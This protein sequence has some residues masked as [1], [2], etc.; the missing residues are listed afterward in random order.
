MLRF[1]AT[2]KT[3][4]GF[5]MSARAIWKGRIRFGSADVPV[6]LYSAVKDR[7]VHFRLLDSR[8]KEPVKQQMVD[9]HTGKVVASDEVRR[10]FQTDD[11]DLVILTDE[12]LAELQPPE[13]R[14]IDV[15]RFGPTA[16]IAQQWYD[17]PYY[18]GPDGDSEGYFALS[19]A[20]EKDGREGLARWVMRKKEYVGSLRAE[21]D[22]LMLITMHSA[23]EI[24]AASSLKPP[25]GRDLSD[26]ELKMAEQLIEAMVDEFDIAA[27][28]DEYRDRVTE[29]VQA[30]AA[31]K[32]VKFPKALP[33]RK[34]K[35][36]AD[37]LE[38]SLSAVKKERASA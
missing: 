21:G 29:L 36:L 18:L 26:R 11:G 12:D 13:S 30:K 24:I 14:D 20:L 3:C 16:T 35:S 27:F 17:R 6:K 23:G 15:L 32:I 1:D 9:P 33:K 19:Q 37:E 38:A 7:A 31:G 8:R 28:R 5:P 34:E 25:A 10:A 22:Y 2:L 4:K